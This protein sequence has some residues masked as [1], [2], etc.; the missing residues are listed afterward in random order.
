M[1]RML[2]PGVSVSISNSEMPACLRALG[3]VR[4]RQN[5][6]LATCA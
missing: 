5:I 6:L 4:T 2:I 3:S 1:G